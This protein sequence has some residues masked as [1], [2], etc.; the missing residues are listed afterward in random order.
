MQSVTPDELRDEQ[1]DAIRSVLGASQ[2]KRAGQSFT[3]ALNARM[4]SGQAAYLH[5]V[6]EAY[7][8][9]I[10]AALRRVIDRAI[11]QD[12]TDDEKA[13]GLRSLWH[14]VGEFTPDPEWV[15]RHGSSHDG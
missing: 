5:A 1:R 11:E 10:S 15:A 3:Y 8:E 2:D 12:R 4:T 9:P 13:K 14:L 6:A 7:D